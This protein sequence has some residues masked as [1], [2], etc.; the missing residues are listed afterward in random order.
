M[1]EFINL[2]NGVHGKYSRD[3]NYIIIYCDGLQI[4]DCDLQI[5]KFSYKDV[6]R[7]VIFNW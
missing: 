7:S 3:G 4:Y 2:W 6:E 5:T 1:T